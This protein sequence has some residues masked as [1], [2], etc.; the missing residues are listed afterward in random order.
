MSAAVAVADETSEPTAS[1]DRRRF[2]GLLAAGAGS[3]ALAGCS[4][5]RDGVGEQGRGSTTSTTGADTSTGADPAGP[6]VPPDQGLTGDPF[7]LGVAS[8]DPEPTSIVLWTR[9]VTEIDDRSGTGG[10]TAE[11]VR[12]RWQVADDE[13]FTEGVRGGIVETAAATGHSVHQVVEDLVPNTWYWY[14]FQVGDWTSPLGRTRTVP[15]DDQQVDELRLVFASCQ[16]RQTGYWTSY[17]HLVDDAPDLVFFLGDYVYEYPG[18]EGPNA[19]P[20]TA[21]PASLADYRLLYASYQRDPALQ[22]AQAVAPWVVTW[23]DHEVENNYAAQSAEKTEDQAGFTARRAAAYQAF[24]EHH[25]LR[26]DPPTADGALRIHRE[27]RYGALATFLVLDGRQYRSDQVCGD[28]IPTVASECPELEDPTRTMLGSDQ[29]R[30]MAERLGASAATWTVLAQQT[31]MKALVLGDLVLNVDQWDGYPKAR[32]RLFDAIT[33]AGAENVVVLTGDIHAGGAADLRQPD[34]SAS[35]QIVAHELVGPGISSAGLGAGLA[36]ALDLEA[37]GIAYANF[38]DN[39]YV[40]CTVTPQR[41][42]AEW[43][44]VETVAEPASDVRVDATVEITAG[45]PGIRRV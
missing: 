32:A 38:A 34:A 7:V 33:E 11:S 26:G 45:T 2:L 39:G 23:D 29:E 44:V 31:V 9:L 4:S 27:V 10:V 6:E 37:M 41:W 18:G 35:G 15:R 28:K 40:R 20:L 21:E 22:A 14:R 19:N 30:W 16:M 13:A 43:V 8:G 5:G 24:W 36:S 42:R 17:P 12:L 25:P 3:V 1:W